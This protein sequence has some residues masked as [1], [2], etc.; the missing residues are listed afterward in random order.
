[1]WLDGKRLRTWTFDTNGKKIKKT[2]ANFD[3]YNP[4]FQFPFIYQGS[5]DMLVDS[6]KD[7]TVN[8]ILTD[9]PYGITQN[10]W[11]E[12]PRWKEIAKQYN[13]ILKD[14]G[15]IAIFG[16]VP[17][18]ID[19]YNEFQ[20]F[21]DFRYDIVWVKG[22]K[23]AMWMSNF[24]PLR[25]HENI[26]VFCKKNT[27]PTATTF[28]IKQIGEK[29]KPYTIKRTI[30]TT[31]QGNWN[32][33][34]FESQSD[35]IRFPV[36]VPGVGGSDKEYLGVPTQKPEKIIELLIRGL[37]NPNDVV[38]DPYLGSGT[39][40]KVAMEHARLCIGAEVDPKHY[41]IIKKRLKTIK[42]RKASCRERV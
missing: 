14:N 16:T 33:K 38:C 37:S 35:G 23:T 8:L 22:A 29:G 5:A 19:I 28:N 31:N 32:N 3:S 21:F 1:M 20:E 41:P 13:R 11:D 42:D 18:I 26:F 7:K 17:N 10:R 9:P 15:L 36:S 39:T 30:A 40:A 2:I 6:L 12:K 27:K 4:I 24:K 34:K 25:T